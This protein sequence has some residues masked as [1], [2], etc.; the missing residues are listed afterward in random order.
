MMK[1]VDMIKTIQLAEARAWL[2][3]KDAQA[4]NDKPKEIIRDMQERWMT[5]KC[6]MSALDIDS[7]VELVESKMALDII[8][9]NLKLAF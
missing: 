6:L 4:K 3:L 5:L 2:A 8:V 7:D 9:N 1:K